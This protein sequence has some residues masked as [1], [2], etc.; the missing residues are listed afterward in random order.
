MG[1]GATPLRIPHDIGVARSAR[2]VMEQTKGAL[3]HRLNTSTEDAFETMRPYARHHRLRLTV[4]AQEVLDKELLAVVPAPA[5][6]PEQTDDG[7]GAVQRPGDTALSAEEGPVGGG[8]GRLG[9]ID[10]G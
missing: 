3:M 7:Q 5:R 1:P 9:D 4:V 10:T 6:L 8:D 2:S